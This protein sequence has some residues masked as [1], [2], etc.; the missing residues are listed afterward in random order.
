MGRA[1]AKDKKK[2]EQ[3]LSQYVV[4][5]PSGLGREMPRQMLLKAR[6]NT[7]GRDEGHRGKAKRKVCRSEIWAKG[8]GRGPQGR[9]QRPE[10]R[11]AGAKLEAR[12][13]G[14]RSEPEARLSGAVE[15]RA[16]GGESR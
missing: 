15:E 4:G 5:D 13:V 7:R 2:R 14:P 11:A 6:R 8:R 1:S 12:A 10:A 16:V 9:D 3:I